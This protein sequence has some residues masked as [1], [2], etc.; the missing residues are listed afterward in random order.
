MSDYENYIPVLP[1]TV[2]GARESFMYAHLA[3][4]GVDTKTIGTKLTIELSEAWDAFIAGVPTVLK[5]QR[6]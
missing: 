4:R 3:I 5:A 1:V 2:A 6:S